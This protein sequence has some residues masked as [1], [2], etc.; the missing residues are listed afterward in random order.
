[1]HMEHFPGVLDSYEALKISHLHSKAEREK[2][3]E[4][5]FPMSMGVRKKILELQKGK[6]NSV[7]LCYC[8]VTGRGEQMLPF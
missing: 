4:K 3:S 2:A 5:S 8:L 6:Q 1:M 7:V